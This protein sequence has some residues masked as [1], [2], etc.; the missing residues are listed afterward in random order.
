MAIE[1]KNEPA[2]TLQSLLTKTPVIPV[3]SIDNSAHAVS[4]AAAL[5][6]GGIN[7]LEIVLRTPAARQA[8]ALIKSKMPQITIGIGTVLTVDQLQWAKDIGAAFAIS[9]GSTERLLV[10]AKKLAIDF[11]PGVATASEIMRA[12]ELGYDT[13]KLFPAN[14]AGGIQAIKNFASLFPQVSFCPTGGVNQDNL[15]DYAK[16]PNVITIGGSWLAPKDL[17]ATENWTAITNRTKQ[18]IDTINALTQ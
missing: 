9:P 13:M 8:V 5:Q 18:A 2:M 4:L 15:V 10:T 6:A 17:I 11:L 3:L 7:T 12:L 14:L 1:L 16:L